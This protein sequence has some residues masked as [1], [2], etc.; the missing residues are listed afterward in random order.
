MLTIQRNVPLAPLTTLCLGGPADEFASCST[1]DDVRQ[2]VRSAV[3]RMVPLHILGGGSNTIV[4]DEGATGL[5]AHI[6]LRGVKM[7]DD[8]DGMLVEAAAGEPW[9]ELVLRTINEGL[10]GLECLSG[11]PGLVGA[12][13]VQNVGAYGQD[14]SETI[15]RVTVLDRGT[16]EERSFAGSECGFRYRQSRFKSADAGRYVVTA[17]TFRLQKNAAPHVRYVELQ[18]YFEDQGTRGSL[19]QGRPALEA[20]RAAVLALRRRK[21]MVIDPADA[22]SRS[23][24]SF[25]MN[26]IVT[27]AGLEKVREHW[28]GGGG[29]DPIPT[30]PTDEGVKIPGAWLVEHA[31]FAKGHRQ[32]GAGISSNHALA[33]INCGGT[34]RELLGLAA[35]IQ[36]A[37]FERFGV[38]LEREPVMLG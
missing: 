8:G 10:G 31:G 34:T 14:V 6:A 3:V 35:A 16:L 12:T 9:D 4:P 24:G 28:S 38:Q 18:R 21:S 33:L 27:P 2:A 22:N 1:I 17:V 30:F 5:V 29:K 15:V 19:T 13:P 20:V 32:G 11:I 26:V 36:R 7:T 25:F 37:V 23:V